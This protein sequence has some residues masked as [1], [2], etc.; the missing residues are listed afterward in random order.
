MQLIDL[1]LEGALHHPL[2]QPLDAE[3]LGY[4]QTSSVVTAPH[5]PYLST[6]SPT[7]G[8]F[9]KRI[10]KYVKRLVSSQKRRFTRGL[11]ENWLLLG[12]GG[13]NPTVVSLAAIS[14]SEKVLHWISVYRSKPTGFDV[15][16][17][18]LFQW[19]FEAIRGAGRKTNV[20]RQA[21][22][23]DGGWWRDFPRRSG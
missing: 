20:L 21:E 11:R 19:V 16:F 15:H 5:F 7:S 13:V 17:L 3:H 8:R 9:R 18:T 12:L 23:A 2:A 1:A 10:A 22:G 4:H 14:V 6:Q